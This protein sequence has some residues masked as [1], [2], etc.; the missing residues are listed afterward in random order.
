VRFERPLTRA[1]AKIETEDMEFCVIRF[2]AGTFLPVIPIQRFLES[3]VCLPLASRASFWLHGMNWEFPR[4]E[5]VESFVSRLVRHEVL[6]RDPLV[7]A[8]LHQQ[9]H[10]VSTRTVRRRFLKATG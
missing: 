1:K 8:V 4:F 7:S 5:D 9:P 2:K 3:D 6:L 10:D